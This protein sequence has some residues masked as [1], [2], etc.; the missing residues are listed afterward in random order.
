ML[1]RLQQ[2]LGR[3]A[4]ARKAYSLWTAAL[5]KLWYG[6]AIPFYMTA[7]PGYD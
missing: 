3:S 4:A 6:L 7:D 1:G 2:E 5:H